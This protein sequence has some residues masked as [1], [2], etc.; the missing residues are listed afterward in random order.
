MRNVPG[1]AVSL[2]SSRVAPGVAAIAVPAGWRRP[3]DG[4]GAVVAD[5]EVPAAVA[6][7]PHAV[8]PGGERGAERDA[9]A[10]RRRCAGRGCGPSSPA[11]R[12]SRAARG[13]RG[14]TEWTR[15]VTS[16]DS[17][18]SVANSTWQASQCD[19]AA[20]WASVGCSSRTPR[21]CGHTVSH[22]RVSRPARV[23]WSATRRRSTSG[24]FHTRAR[25]RI[26]IRWRSGSSPVRSQSISASTHAAGSPAA[27]RA[28]RCW[29]RRCSAGSASTGGGRRRIS[30]R[31]RSSCSASAGS[32]RR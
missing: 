26:W 23:A 5:V 21:Q 32:T 24:S 10:G 16:T 12:C 17:G 9:A 7:A 18:V 25:S 28:S 27:T 19:C 1:S 29:R 31:G 15:N 20:S 6:V 3:R 2:T 22:D 13:R 14:S 4:V 11:R 8:A 30:G